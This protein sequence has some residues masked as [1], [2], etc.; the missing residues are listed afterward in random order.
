MGRP[1]G[2]INRQKPFNDALLLTLR[3]NPLAL[4]RIAAKLVERAEEGDL[5]AIREI[6]DRLDGKPV[7]AIDLHDVPVERLTDAQ[8]RFLAAGGLEDDNKTLLLPP[9]PK[10]MR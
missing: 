6:A 5:A 7:P 3:S 1:I 10:S 8:L 2:S 9:G 4:R